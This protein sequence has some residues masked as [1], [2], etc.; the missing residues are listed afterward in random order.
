MTT[1]GK[2]SHAAD[3]TFH[4]TPFSEV[5]SVY[6]DHTLKKAK[7]KRVRNKTNIRSKV[8]IVEEFWRAFLG[9]TILILFQFSSS[10]CL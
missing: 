10:K 5:P 8:F 6:K 2:A 9:K 7:E 4:S 1:L 3:L